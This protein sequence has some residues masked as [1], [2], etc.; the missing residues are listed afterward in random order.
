V[1]SQVVARARSGTDDG[2]APVEWIETEIKLAIRRHPEAQN[3]LL[4]SNLVVIPTILSPA[5]GTEFI[6]RGHVR[7]LL[8]RVA[9]GL[10]TRPGTAAE[11]CNAMAEVA[12]A[13]LRAEPISRVART[14]RSR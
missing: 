3:D 6:Y 7:E 1:L 12:K 2:L 8:E 13:S 11:C 9:L 14:A 4:H 5:W 10:E